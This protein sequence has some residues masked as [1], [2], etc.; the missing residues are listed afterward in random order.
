MAAC[1]RHHTKALE[2]VAKAVLNFDSALL[3]EKNEASIS[4]YYPLEHDGTL[5][6][7]IAG[8]LSYVLDELPS[9]L[10]SGAL[11]NSAESIQ[12]HQ[13]VGMFGSLMLLSSTLAAIVVVLKTEAK[14]GDIEEVVR[15]AGESLI[16]LA[17]SRAAVAVK[18]NQANTSVGDLAQTT[19]RGA[20]ILVTKMDLC[21]PKTLGA[22]MLQAY[23]RLT[24]LSFYGA[25]FG[26]L[27][28]QVIDSDL[29]LEV[30]IR[31]HCSVCR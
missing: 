5:R 15:V 29:S 28:D 20:L 16:T 12:S 9:L 11:K 23:C 27:L 24:C 7:P 25:A 2:I 18:P 6:V 4:K 10:G 1:W 3:S 19:G 21:S 14:S 17:E 8:M 13:L 22:S 31:S 26:S 30:W